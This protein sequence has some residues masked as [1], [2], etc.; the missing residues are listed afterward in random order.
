M[1]VFNHILRAENEYAAAR[2]TAVFPRR[3][4][5]GRGPAASGQP[6]VASRAIAC[7]GVGLLTLKQQMP[8]ECTRDPQWI[9]KGEGSTVLSEAT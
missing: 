7:R 8:L 6:P 4:P 2:N 3:R 5:K 1:K 9:R